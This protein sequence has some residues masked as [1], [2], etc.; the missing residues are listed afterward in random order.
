MVGYNKTS[1]LSN[2]WN[3]TA[4]SFYF[5]TKLHIPLLQ[6]MNLIHQLTTQKMKGQKINADLEKFTFFQQQLLRS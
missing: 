2:Y 3:Y 1:K 5:T 4:P 6:E